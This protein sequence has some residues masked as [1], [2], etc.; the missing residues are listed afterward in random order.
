MTRLLELTYWEII[1]FYSRLAVGLT[2]LTKTFKTH[3]DV[4]MQPT[5]T[6]TWILLHHMQ[7]LHYPQL[8]YLLLC[9]ILRI[10]AM[11]S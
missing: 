4:K 2:T 8:L 3:K 9:F 5:D 7:L 6:D 11:I 10:I 1:Q